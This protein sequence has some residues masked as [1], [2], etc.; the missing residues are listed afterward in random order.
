MMTI[1]ECE[2]DQ[3]DLERSKSN[4]SSPLELINNANRRQGERNLIKDYKKIE[5]PQSQ[6]RSAFKPIFLDDGTESFN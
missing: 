6:I 3:S 5:R 4:I 1:F 2:I